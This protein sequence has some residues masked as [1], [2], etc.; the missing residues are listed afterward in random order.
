MGSNFT[1]NTG[2]AKIPLVL[3]ILAIIT[4]VGG[5]IAIVKPQLVSVTPTPSPVPTSIPIP[6]AT[7][8][9]EFN[10]STWKTYR[11]EQYGFEI[12]YPQVLEDI[13]KVSTFIIAEGDDIS[14][15]INRNAIFDCDNV[16]TWIAT[17]IE[18]KEKIVKELLVNLTPA[19]FISQFEIY[20]A[21][22]YLEKRLYTCIKSNPPT[23]LDFR[24]LKYSDERDKKYSTAFDQ[25]LSTF[26][27]IEP[28]SSSPS[29]APKI[30]VLSPNGGEQWKIGE[31]HTIRWSSSGYSGNIDISL[32]KQKMD[33]GVEI[34]TLYVAK[35]VP[36]T[37]NYSWTIPASFTIDANRSIDISSGNYYK[38]IVGAPGSQND[39]YD[40]SD[41]F[42][43]INQ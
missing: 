33:F 6:I 39:K 19:K 7:S 27:F 28:S 38:I 1:H 4:A 40:A 29:T 42:F 17:A 34:A 18:G 11:N 26:K 3:I 24:I 32:L 36:N 35:G 13:K 2:F 21:R 5:Y 22:G 31:T 20:S 10:T 41:N 14:L 23:V 15:T 30:T 12:R 43:T 37:E 16:K 25:I 8:T 9:S